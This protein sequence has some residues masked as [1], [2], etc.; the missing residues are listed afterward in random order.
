MGPR[1]QPLKGAAGM[2]VNDRSLYK[3]SCVI[4]GG[5]AQGCF[6]Y[7][8][9]LRERALALQDARVPVPAPTPVWMQA[10]ILAQPV[11]RARPLAMRQIGGDRVG[12]FGDCFE[13][14]AGALTHEALDLRD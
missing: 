5:I 10:E 14:F 7:V 11:M 3:N 6:E 1:F 9:I 13:A 2:R 4:L 8:V 12:G